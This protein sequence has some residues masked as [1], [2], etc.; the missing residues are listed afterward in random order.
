MRAP[1]LVSSFFPVNEKFLVD[2]KL[3][4]AKQ[5]AVPRLKNA[6]DFNT[7]NILIWQ[8]LALG[9][10]LSSGVMPHTVTTKV[11]LSLLPTRAIMVSISAS[12]LIS[13]D[14]INPLQVDAQLQN[15]GTWFSTE[16]PRRVLLQD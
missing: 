5:F 16:K 15:L 10:A 7:M 12:N 13:K 6:I 8:F 9:I 2:F 1:A 14:D 3:E 11:F 4:W